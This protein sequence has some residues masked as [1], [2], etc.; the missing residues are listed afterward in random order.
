MSD[1]FTIRLATLDDIPTILE[2][3]RGM[4]RDM[5]H[6]DSAKL[7][8]MEAKFLP[9]VR[10]KMEQ[11]E[12]LTWLVQTSSGTI[13]AGGS[14]W[15]Q[16]WPVSPMNLSGCRGYVLNVYTDPDYRRRG[17]ARQIMNTILTWCQDRDIHL[18]VLN[19]S[20]DGRPLYESMGFQPSPVMI[21]H[22]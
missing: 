9:W 10:A 15:V 14:L 21:K 22:V 18:V 2:H 3:R 13:A 5:G 17:L 7:D 11:G 4:F 19:A 8:A 1:E 12:Y 20:P 16:E 6:T